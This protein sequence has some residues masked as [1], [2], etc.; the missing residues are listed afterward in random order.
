MRFLFLAYYHPKYI[1]PLKNWAKAL[2]AK[3]IYTKEMY[4]DKFYKEDVIRHL[5]LN[6]DVI[7]YFGHGIRGAWSGYKRI[8]IGDIKKNNSNKKLKTII[9]LSCY[10]MSQTQK[11]EKSFCEQLL[12]NS[13]ADCVIGFN[14]KVRYEANLKFLNILMTDFLKK[15]PV[16]FKKNISDMI[17]RN[18]HLPELQLKKTQ[19][20][21]KG[22]QSQ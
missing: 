4:P 11:H 16:D 13:I 22:S 19:R 9:S 7:I 20:H 12:D 2:R 10:G 3:G 1:N 17:K 21:N 8:T 6:Y 18:I 5:K 15:T 14:G